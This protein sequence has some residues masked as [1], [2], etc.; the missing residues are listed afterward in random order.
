MPF[1]PSLPILVMISSR[2]ASS[3]ALKL[4]AFSVSGLPFTLDGMSYS[5][6]SCWDHLVKF[7]L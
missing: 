7:S 1:S 2:S 5:F 4:V 3:I 6:S